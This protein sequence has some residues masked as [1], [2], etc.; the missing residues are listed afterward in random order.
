MNKAVVAVLLLLCGCTSAAEKEQE[1][2]EALIAAAKQVLERGLFD[3]SSAEYQNV[4]VA[5]PLPASTAAN[6][7]GIPGGVCGR[8]NAKNRFG[9]YVG[10][11]PFIWIEGDEAVGVPLSDQSEIVYLPGY[12]SVGWSAYCSD[13]PV[14]DSVEA[15]TD[16]EVMVA[17][18]KVSSL[19]NGE[20]AFARCRACHSINK[21]GPASIGPNLYGI[22]GKQ[23][24]SAGEYSYS[25][26][27]KSKQGEWQWSN[28]DRYLRNP[29]SY[30]PGTKMSFT[31]VSDVQTRANLIA[32]LNE[33]SDEPIELP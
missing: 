27:L 13:R 28:L 32:Y 19:E 8:V 23:I 10:F 15:A 33:Q 1:A 29:Q 5:E 16:Q 26:A 20:P 31:G 21:G 30:A 11:R 18:L 6:R 24:A 22:V 2:Q 12:G 7:Q 3:P 4:R 9:G 17:A 25:D 14:Q